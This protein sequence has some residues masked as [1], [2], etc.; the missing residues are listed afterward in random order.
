[1]LA[2][3]GTPPSVVIVEG[4]AGI[5]KSRLVSELGARPELDGH[6]WAL[7]ACRGIRE[8]FPLG[9]VLEAVSGLGDAL[10][11]DELSPVAGALR[12]LLPE[13][14]S[15]LP[16]APQPLDDRA[17][18]RHRVFRGLT[19]VL[20][21]LGP[22]VLVLEDLHWADP[23]TIEFLDYLL[24]HPPARLSLVVTFR[25]D[26]ASAD[27]RTLTARLPGEVGCADILLPPLDAEQT[28]RLAAA[29]IG[30]GWVSEEFAS[31]LCQRASG[32]P[33][34]VEELLALLGPRTQHAQRGGDW[35]R[36]ALDELDVP[37]GIRDLALHRVA[38][39]SDDA[40]A[41]VEAAAVLQVP[42]P[43]PVLAAVC[44]M[45]RPRLLAAL[46]EALARGLLAETGS[47]VGF[48]HLLAAQA[49]YEATSSPRRRDLHDRAAAVLG[50]L[51]P[52]PLGQV[53]HHLRQAGRTYA[54]VDA[55]ER[56]ADQAVELGDDMEAVRLLLDVLRHDRLGHGRRGRLAVKLARA[57][58]QTVHITTEV[59][60]LLTE[61]L[62]G[63]LPAAVRGELGF[64]LALLHE[65]AGADAALVRQLYTDAVD[66][67]DR[68]DLKAWVLTGLAIPT[69]PGVPLAEHRDW[70]R[71]ALAVLPSVDDPD[72]EVFLLGKAAMVMAATG[73]GAWRELC[74]RIDGRTG[75]VPGR[76]REVNA[77]QSLG[78]AAA[79][80]GHYRHADR[81]L[82]AA[83]H[84]AAVCESRELDLRVRS[85]RAVLDY[86]RG[87]WEGLGGAV[88][89]LL[90]ELAD[91]PVGRIDVEVVAGCL[92]L[93]DGDLRTAGQ[94]LTAVALRAEG[95]GGYEVSACAVD[96]LGRL[97]VTRGDVDGV[98]GHVRDFLTAAA[99]KG[100]WLP[101]ARVLPAATE[102]LL[103]AGQ[104]DEAA[105]LVTRTA[106]R[107]GKL[108]APL[109]PAA[110]GRSRASIAAGAGR[111]AQAARGFAR[112]AEQYG[113]LEAHYEVAQA[114]EQAADAWYAAGEPARA[115]AQLQVALDGYQDLGATWD[116]DRATR[117]ARR[118]G[119]AVP[120]RR[121]G[122]G[123]G[124]GD[125]L[126]PREREVADL[127]AAGRSN[128]QI[129]RE[130][131]LSPKTVDKH[132]GAA[133]RKLG[134]P[135]RSALARHLDREP[136]P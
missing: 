123:R 131:F 114:A 54:W 63:D 93:A 62:A 107:L 79:Y 38:G 128:K 127:A 29:I 96:A 72:F 16:P 99:A 102:V 95:I 116:L 98:V 22:A 45:P 36:Q 125:Q 110:T 77:Y 14:A 7:G 86:G 43:V 117:S 83:A 104:P 71:R 132:I 106:R 92:A 20:V 94:R 17:G 1:M 100:W 108:D 65:A 130:L 59:T 18:E 41:V 112:A 61:V 3:V 75:G 118:Y 40:R 85:A 25:G 129:A 27:L 5:G 33:F 10:S 66:L 70:L 4:E 74:R 119:I 111:W 90:E 76:R 15:R 11:P 135:S 124:Y 69:A 6:R 26:E 51:E 126:S 34:A 60:G 78:M 67:L 42:V 48:R 113:Q 30:T 115:V 44:A 9:P 88:A 101:V 2:A 82:E 64:R 47:D 91:Y 35:A 53:A 58:I 121:A 37:G 105:A 68:P 8:P 50:R 12:P 81:L 133:L 46:E 84:G 56:A 21:A 23:Q 13:L 122:G 24:A 109:A 39:L 134:V 120:A 103:A 80:A 89:V 49:A 55:A 136:T 31:H 19:E 73:D 97:A 52:V 87:S 57:A 28:G 32:L